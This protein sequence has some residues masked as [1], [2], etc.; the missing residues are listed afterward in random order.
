[1]AN[2]VRPLDP[3][4]I[5]PHD[6]KPVHLHDAEGVRSYEDH[7]ALA[8]IEFTERP[9]NELAV[10]DDPSY[11]PA[12][13]DPENPARM[14]MA[15]VEVETYLGRQR[16]GVAPRD[17]AYGEPEAETLGARQVGP[18]KRTKYYIVHAPNPD[19]T[20]VPELNAAE[21]RAVQEAI[22][23]MEADRLEAEAAAMLW[24]ARALRGGKTL[25]LGAGDDGP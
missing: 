13:A 12:H 16:I 10:K 22:A 1:M 25:A 18:D 24:Q 15:T 9:T 3:A 19:A 8:N 6:E 2:E 23:V 4:F 7:L 21:Q 17:G 5:G 20:I 14:V 11:I